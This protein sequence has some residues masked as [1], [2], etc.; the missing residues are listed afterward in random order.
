MCKQQTRLNRGRVGCCLHCYVSRKRVRIRISVE[1]GTAE[2]FRYILCIKT[3]ILALS[4]LCKLRGENGVSAN[5]NCY[6]V[7]TSGR[8][9]V[10]S[11]WR[12]ECLETLTLWWHC[13]WRKVECGAVSSRRI[14]TGWTNISLN[15][16]REDVQPTSNKLQINVH[17]CAVHKLSE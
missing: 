5:L 17:V 7:N 9:L 15:R 12:A 3:E 2:I 4:H 10:G 14:S 1:V 6:F 13:W 8:A 16:A 11:P